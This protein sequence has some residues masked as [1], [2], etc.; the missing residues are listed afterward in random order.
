MVEFRTRLSSKGLEN[1]RFDPAD[2]F[3]FIVGS[4]Y[5][6]CSRFVA[7]FLSPMI[8][9]LLIADPTISSYLL[10]TM[11]DVVCFDEFFRISGGSEVSINK[12]NKLNLLLTAREL[13]NTELGLVIEEHFPSHPI[14]IDNAVSNYLDQ[15][16]CG[17]EEATEFSAAHFSEF[18]RSSLSEL[19]LFDL[20]VILSMNSLCIESEDSLF[21]FIVGR[22]FEAYFELFQHVRF[23]CLS[24]DRV[25][26]FCEEGEALNICV[27]SAIWHQI[28]RRLKLSVDMPSLCVDSVRYLLKCPFKASAPLSGIISYLTT[29]YG[30]NVA[31]RNVV[32]VTASSVDGGAARNAVDVLADNFWISRNEDNSWLRYD[33]KEMRVRPTHYS[34][35]SRYNGGDNDV[36]PKNWVVE[37]SNDGTTWK[38]IDERLNNE[39]LK[40]KNLEGA[41]AV[42]P[43]DYCRFIQIRQQG[44]S[45]YKRNCYLFLISAFE[46]FGDLRE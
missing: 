19:A 35:R 41:F 27:N 20:D 36:Y 32:G 24:L 9:R 1:V 18:D 46:I 3:V 31:D 8:A 13:E 2:D 33:F 4:A 26:K 29:K 21:D 15:K 10:C 39:D 23:E 43:C 11:N 40:G 6:R 17:A 5:F 12:S 16:L 45:W 30:G 42:A 38:I 37:V 25:H 34:V 22:G 7:A 28:S 14:T 44:Y